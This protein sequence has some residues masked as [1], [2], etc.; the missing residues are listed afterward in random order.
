M[1][2]K[3]ADIARPLLPMEAVDVP[4]IGGEVIVRGLTLS[5]R[6]ELGVKF[7]DA[8][9]RQMPEMLARC[10][11]DADHEPVFDADEWEAFGAKHFDVVLRLADK[12][13]RLSGFDKDD[14][15]K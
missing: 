2:L 9:F 6:L 1:A 3:K 14:S 12:A 15:G 10:V 8:G 13:Q 4:E 5:Q 11:V 7:R